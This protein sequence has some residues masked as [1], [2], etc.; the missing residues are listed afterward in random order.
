VES[1]S[2]RTYAEKRRA[3]RNMY[4]RNRR[5]R[6]LLARVSPDCAHSRSDT[7]TFPDRIQSRSDTDSIGHSPDRTQTY[8]KSYN[9]R[10]RFALKAQ[11][12]VN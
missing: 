5:T 6:N 9:N 8:V 11:G 3:K 12:G 2:T 1:R 4:R 10:P 7:T